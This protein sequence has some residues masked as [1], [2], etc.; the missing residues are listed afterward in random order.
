MAQQYIKGVCIGRGSFGEVYRAFDTSHRRDVALKLVDL[1][2]ADEEIDVSTL[3]CIVLPMRGF[4][5]GSRDL[6]STSNGK[7]NSFDTYACL[8]RLYNGRSRS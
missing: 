6:C 1:E 5:P 4:S 8:R 7:M 3:G 2:Q